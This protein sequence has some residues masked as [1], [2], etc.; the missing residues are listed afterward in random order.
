MENERIQCSECKGK[1]W[2][3]YITD[4]QIKIGNEI[5]TLDSEIGESEKCRKC[6]GTGYQLNIQ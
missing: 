5:K 4:T 6:S 2:V 3:I 1:G